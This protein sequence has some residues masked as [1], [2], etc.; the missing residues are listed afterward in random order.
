MK[1]AVI[2]LGSWGT[3]VANMLA[4]YGH[5]VC[6]F[7]RDPGFVRE[8]SY[9]RENKKYLPGIA[10]SDGICFTADLQSAVR[11]ADFVVSA[12]PAQGFRRSYESYAEYMPDG[13]VLVNLAKGIEIGTGMRLSEVA[14]AVDARLNGS[15]VALSGPTHAE[16]VAARHPSAIVVASDDEGAA[17]R[18]QSVFSGEYFRV[19]RSSDLAGVEIAGALKNVI[20]VAAGIVDGIG[21][22]DNA[23]AALITRGLAEIARFGIAHG[24]QRDTFSGLAGVGDMIVTC[25]SS[26]SRNL[27]FGRL[28]GGGAHPEQAERSIGMVVEGVHTL[29]A[30]LEK[31]KR[32]TDIE[33]PI[34]EALGRV[35]AGE[36]DPKDAVCSLMTRAFKSEV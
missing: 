32:T 2:A 3:A 1:I 14:R 26:H 31:L 23:K 27:R 35:L 34:T 6:A 11:G 33:M 15:Y 24:A 25:G 13:A 10:L 30:V 29:R 9:S 36:I 16:E 21:Y 18:V 5:E 22:G 8:L 7:A 19:Y 20:A 12:V 28:V 17:L 4:E